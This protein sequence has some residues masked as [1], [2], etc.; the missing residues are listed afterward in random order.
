M[1]LNTKRMRGINS[2]INFNGNGYFFSHNT[3]SEKVAK[4]ILNKLKFDNNTIKL[5]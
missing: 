1:K 5:I 4:V 3:R 2:Y